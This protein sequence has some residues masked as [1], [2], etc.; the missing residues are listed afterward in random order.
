MVYL[1][2]VSAP[3]AVTRRAIS[4]ALVGGAVF[5]RGACLPFRCAIVVRFRGVP[6]R[7]FAAYPP[8][9]RFVRYSTVPALHTPPTHH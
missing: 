3:L 8:A 6:F 2:T 9:L 4:A 1:V 7:A 5:A